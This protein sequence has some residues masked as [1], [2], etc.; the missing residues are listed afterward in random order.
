[1]RAVA[2]GAAEFRMGLF[3]RREG[4]V[5]RQ[6]RLAERADTGYPADDEEPMNPTQRELLQAELFDRLKRLSFKRGD[7]TLASGR[8]SDFYL[9]CR[10][11]T[12]DARGA[13][14]IGQLLY[15]DIAPLQVDAVGGMTM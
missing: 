2:R 6:P 8:K 10:L 9:D 3:R 13:W 14:L 1:P 5:V 12:L 7:F 4:T 15:D 11:T